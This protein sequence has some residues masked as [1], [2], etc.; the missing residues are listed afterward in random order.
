MT[1]L[2]GWSTAKNPDAGIHRRKE[3]SRPAVKPTSEI[4][5]EIFVTEQAARKLP[6]RYS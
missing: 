1:H 6:L 3:A 2:I 5:T 4:G